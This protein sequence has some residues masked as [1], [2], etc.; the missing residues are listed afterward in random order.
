ME[1][2]NTYV[3]DQDDLPPDFDGWAFLHF[4]TRRP[5]YLFADLLNRIYG[6]A[7]SRLDDVEPGG[8][9]WPMYYHFDEVRHLAFFLIEC[10]ATASSDLLET[11]DKVLLVLGEMARAEVDKIYFEMVERHTFDPA[12]LLA[13]DHATLI[14]QLLSDFTVAR[15]LD[16]DQLPQ[17][18]AQQRRQRQLADLMD[19]L[20]TS[21]ESRQLNLSPTERLRIKFKSSR[22]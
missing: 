7:L 6:Y 8:A 17:K 9:R 19:S 2:P 21:I 13:V 14:D 4:R 5:S 10:P 15:V 18:P 22:Q 11:G 12:D 3:L 20:L 16:F 1:R